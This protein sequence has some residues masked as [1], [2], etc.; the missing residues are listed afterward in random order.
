MPFNQ[1]IVGNAPGCTYFSKGM[2][3]VCAIHLCYPFAVVHQSI[4]WI[5]LF[6]FL[7]DIQYGHASVGSQ[8]ILT[9]QLVFHQSLRFM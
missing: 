5:V 9:L 4:N 1:W 2:R 8:G 6:F 7:P 3:V